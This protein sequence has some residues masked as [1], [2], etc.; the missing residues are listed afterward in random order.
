MSTLQPK[1]LN[2]AQNR[3]KCCTENNRDNSYKQINSKIGMNYIQ[4]DIQGRCVMC[5]MTRCVPPGIIF[6]TP[7]CI[8][9]LFNEV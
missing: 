3:I 1:D 9:S 6:W 7:T 8:Y 5:N 4:E 2:N